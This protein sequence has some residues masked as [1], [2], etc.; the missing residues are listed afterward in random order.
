MRNPNG[1][2]GICKLGGKRRKPFQV[3]VTIGWE[4]NEETGQAKQLYKTLGYYK[5]RPEAMLALATYNKNP[6]SFNSSTTTFK[7]IWEAWSKRK[8]DDKRN[9]SKALYYS[10][11][12]AYKAAKELHDM[13]FV[14]IKT[15]HLPA[16][17]DNCPNRADSL[18]NIKMLFRQLF[19]YA[20]QNDIGEKDYSQYVEVEAESNPKLK[21]VPFSDKERDLLWK[22]IEVVE[23][24]DSI[25]IMIYSGVR[26][27]ELLLLETATIDLENRTMMGGIKT[28]AGK[29]RIIPINKKILPLIAKRKAEGYDFLISDNGKPLNYNAYYNN[30]WKPIMSKLNLDHRPHDCRHTCAT[31]LDDAGANKISIKRI[32]GHA[33]KSVTEKYTHKSVEELKKAID[34][35]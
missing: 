9:K 17:I 22:S 14:D 24:V 8:F 16:I 23:N 15:A 4:E 10:Y 20:L 28:E 34:L 1:Y 2:G 5:S 32:L 29:D 25:L 19:Q 7:E 35:I 12:A 3:R 13:K 21:R 33:V 27:S 6:N 11:S 31:L 30:Y 26:P 18:N